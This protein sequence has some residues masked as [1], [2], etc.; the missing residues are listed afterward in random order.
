[1][2]DN[3]E[4]RR[5]QEAIFHE[6]DTPEC[7]R[8]KQIYVEVKRKK[9]GLQNNMEDTRK[10][11]IVFKLDKKMQPLPPGDPPYFLKSLMNIQCTLC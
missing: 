3:E 11:P 6:Q 8:V 7:N 1:M 10:G 4:S 5:N 9:H 2:A